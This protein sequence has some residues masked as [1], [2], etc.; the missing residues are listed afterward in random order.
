MRQLFVVYTLT[1]S[2]L[3]MQACTKSGGGKASLPPKGEVA[4]VVTP[5]APPS[6]AE[7]AAAPVAE[8]A[9][10][11]VAEPAAAPVAEPAGS[12]AEPGT[13]VAKPTPGTVAPQGS[14]GAIDYRLTGQ[15]S[16]L[17]R[18]QLTFRV[19]GFIS[20]VLLKPGTR[21]KQ[22]EVIATLDDRDFQLRLELAK[23]RRD[24]AAV[25]AATAEKEYQREQELK[26]ANASTASSF[27]RIK[28]SYDV[29]RVALRL[30]Q[31]DLEQAELAFKDTKLTAPYDCV[32]STQFKFDGESVQMAP[33]SPVVEVYDTAEPEV[34]LS[35]PERLMGQIQSGTRLKLTIP[36]A[37]FAGAGE[38]LRIVPVINERSRTFQVTAKFS[39]YDAKVVPGSYAEASIE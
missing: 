13:T 22:G 19:A 25:Q 21:A 11:P 8:P 12:Q 17:R 6:P 34:T 27:D 9:A 30:A 32:V 5:P 1:T 20:S 14:S 24:S 28:S 16:A 4:A 36:S 23:A 35:A 2:V 37:G 29:S 3:L 33:P 39:S 31:L 15:V 18:S 7:P 10:A 26:K 38:V